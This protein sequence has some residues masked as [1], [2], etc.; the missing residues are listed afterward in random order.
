MAGPAAVIPRLREGWQRARGAWQRHPALSAVQT[1]LA[2]GLLAVSMARL[3]GRWASAHLS[4]LYVALVCTSP[5]SSAS[6]SASC[7][8]SAAIADP[9]ARAIGSTRVRGSLRAM[10][11]TGSIIIS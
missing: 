2:V 10:H 5:S 11:P 6:S 9:R 4:L 7:C 3:T 8:G 1:F